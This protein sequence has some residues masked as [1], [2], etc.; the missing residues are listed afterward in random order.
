MAVPRQPCRPVEERQ[1][2]MPVGPLLVQ[3]LEDNILIHLIGEL[4]ESIAEPCVIATIGLENSQ[5]F[6]DTGIPGIL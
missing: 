5:D 1:R 4:T 3:D 6:T 2:K